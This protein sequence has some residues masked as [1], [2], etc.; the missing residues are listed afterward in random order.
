MQL[1][2]SSRRAAVV[3]GAVVLVAVLVVVLLGVLVHARCGPLL[4]LDTAVSRALYAGDGRPGWLE[5]VLQVAT[6]PGTT[7][8]RAVVAVPVLAWLAARRAWWTAGWVAAAAALVG[9]LTTAV[10]EL[11]GRARPPFAEGGDRLTSLSFPSGHSSG[12]AVLVAGGL[13]LAWPSLS[14]PARRSWA[15]AGAALALLVG[16]TRL[17]LGVHYLSDVLAGWC[18][19]LAWTLAVVLGAGALPG[20]R[21]ALRPRAEVAR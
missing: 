15:A 18:L 9:P 21:A 3:L 8:V 16:A 17:V 11:V 12:V 10:K 2:P 14:P 1:P 7:A 5:A 20:G 19:G 6:A 4:R 13:V